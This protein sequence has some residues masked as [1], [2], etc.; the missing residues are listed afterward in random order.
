M[1]ASRFSS[2]WAGDSLEDT[3]AR[4][5]RVR[6]FARLPFLAAWRSHGRSAGLAV[7][8]MICAGRKAWP[9]LRAESWA[10]G[11]VRREDGRRWSPPARKLGSLC[12]GRAT[13]GR[14]SLPRRSR[15][16]E[17]ATE[18]SVSVEMGESKTV[19]PASTREETSSLQNNRLF[20]LGSQ[21]SKAK[22]SP[23]VQPI[24]AERAR[25]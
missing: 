14:H 3:S 20:T 7:V 24:C 18:T 11:R 19:P 23:H 22:S 5:L 12:R 17:G 25:G 15:I 1:S 4:L 2:R 8:A 16:K 21:D 13:G 6:A 10:E 9:G